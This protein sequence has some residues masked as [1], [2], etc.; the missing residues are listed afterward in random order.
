MVPAVLL[1]SVKPGKVT[2]LS[3]PQG[4]LKSLSDGYVLQ[5]FLCNGASCWWA[6]SLQIRFYKILSSLSQVFYWRCSRVPLS[7]RNTMRIIYI[8]EIFLVATL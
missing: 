8:I 2:P 5:P 7:S 4:S 6:V 1:T 3:G